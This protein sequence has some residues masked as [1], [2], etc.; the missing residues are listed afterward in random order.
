[1]SASQPE[2]SRASQTRLKPRQAERG[3]WLS[4]PAQRRLAFAPHSAVLPNTEVTFSGN[5]ASHRLLSHTPTHSNNRQTRRTGGG[6]ASEGRVCDGHRGQGGGGR[7]AGLERVTIQWGDN[8]TLLNPQTPPAHDRDTTLR[9]RRP[10]SS[11]HRPVP[12]P[13]SDTPR[14]RH[15]FFLRL[16][17]SSTESAGRARLKGGLG[18]AAPRDSSAKPPFRLERLA[19]TLLVVC[20]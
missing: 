6:R 5:S 20:T 1:M 18:L 12:S 2:Q 7:W 16:H 10:S 11:S 15:T 8:G 19:L 3:R 14:V 4:S 17:I 9:P 13:R